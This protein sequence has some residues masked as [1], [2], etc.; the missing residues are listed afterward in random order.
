MTTEDI[1]FWSMVGTWV[2]G[3][4]TI[5][6]VTLS[7][8]L[9]ISERRVSL[10]ITSDVYDFDDGSEKMI[11][12]I[13]N[14]GSRP[15]TISNHACIALQ[16]GWFKKKCLGIGTS[17]ISF[18]NDDRYPCQLNSGDCLNFGINLNNQDGNWLVNLKSNF[19][20]NRSLS[21]LRI[22]V[23]PNGSKPIKAK[24]GKS[25]MQRLK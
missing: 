11:I 25:I 18:P 8:Y 7:L 4:G 5:L 10:F 16:S 24:L 20:Q 15:V 14:N 17:Y 1:Q 21:S 12:K 6:A 2:A 19:L 9:A 13:V 3:I 22:I 23:Y